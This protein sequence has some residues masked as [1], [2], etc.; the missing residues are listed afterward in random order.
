[1]NYTW[2]NDNNEA[3]QHITTAFSDDDF[4]SASRR[5]TFGPGTS[6]GIVMCVSV[7]V[8]VDSLVESDEEFSIMFEVVTTGSSISTGNDVTAVTLID[9]EGLYARLHTIFP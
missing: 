6:Q 1:M 8:Y 9:S 7:A 3:H 4:T 5:A 2:S